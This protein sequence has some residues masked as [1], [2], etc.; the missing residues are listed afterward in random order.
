MRENVSPVFAGIGPRKSLL[1]TP[2]DRFPR[3]RGDR[4]KD[5]TIVQGEFVFPPCSRG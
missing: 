4:P 1:E 3:V 5:L 2:N